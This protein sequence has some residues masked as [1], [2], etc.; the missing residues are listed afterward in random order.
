MYSVE[1]D[2]LKINFIQR[3]MYEDDHVRIMDLRSFKVIDLHDFQIQPSTI[4]LTN[5]SSTYNVHVSDQCGYYQDRT[6]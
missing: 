6:N 4:V 2:I 5:K 3:K 1:S